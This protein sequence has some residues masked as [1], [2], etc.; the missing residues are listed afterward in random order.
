[1]PRKKSDDP[2]VKKSVSMPTSLYERMLKRME[3][4]GFHSESAYLQFLTRNDVVRQDNAIIAVER[5]AQEKA[6][7]QRDAE[8]K[9][10]GAKKSGAGK[11]KGRKR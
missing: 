4:L 8:M 9:S 5:P 1:M 3:T 7:Q 6:E 10:S 2:A 11:K